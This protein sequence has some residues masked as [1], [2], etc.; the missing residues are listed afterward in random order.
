M[1]TVQRFFRRYIFSAAGIVI[2]FFLLNC[3]L[4]FIVLSL[5]FFC[6]GKEGN[7]S[8]AE[9][10]GYISETGEGIE[11]APQGKEMLEDSRVW[12][13]LLDESGQVIWEEG[14][15]K[16]LPKQYSLSQ[17]AMFSRWY[18]EDW[19]VNV[20]E[21]QDGL[22]V[23]G[24]EKNSIVKYSYTMR[25]SYLRL[26]FVSG[27]LIFLGNFILMLLL[28]L[29]SIRRLEKSAGP[30]LTGIQQMA[31]GKPCHL[32]EK[33]E[34][35][36]I[37][38]SLNQASAFLQKKDGTRAQW[39][40]G[41]SHDIRTPLSM[42][43]GYASELE[44]MP[45]LSVEARNQAGIIRRQGQRIKALVDNLN[46]STKLE[47]SIP[48]IHKKNLAPAELARQ[49]ISDILNEGL[50]GQYRIEF[51]ETGQVPEAFFKGDPFLLR[52]MLENLIRNSILHN[53][54]GCQILVSV[55]MQKS[56]CCFVVQ[57]KG[58]GVSSKALK[59]LNQEN[60]LPAEPEAVGEEDHGL[61]LRIVK[62]IVRLHNGN[63]EFSQTTPHGLTVKIFLRNR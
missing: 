15:P 13:M 6:E 8:I 27:F 7:F 9:L 61:G 56:F 12:A 62:Q 21:R 5:W 14:L 48:S 39:I 51:L 24:F 17:V 38:A 50:S 43:L 25:T 34:L 22:L 19:P 59:E 63:I 45:D 26:L 58:Q 16:E 40:R 18:L 23:A 60:Y 32:E 29:G 10:S 53:P 4:I 44:E 30:I 35:A 31:G 33:G 28:F 47:Y 49:V 46:L 3:M 52:R 42:I 37:N 2:L 57:D 55:D 54:A 20:W 11:I 41:V 36:E 1:N